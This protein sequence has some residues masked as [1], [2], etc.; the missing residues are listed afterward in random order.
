EEHGDPQRAE[1]I[2]IQCELERRPRYDARWL[3]LH[4]REQSIPWVTRNDWIPKLPSWPGLRW[5]TFTLRRGFAARVRAETI[6]A[7][8]EHAE[9]VFGMAPVEALE[10]DRPDM[11]GLAA[12]PGLSRLR[13]LELKLGYLTCDDLRR[14]I[15][16]PRSAGLTEMCLS[17]GGIARDG[18]EALIQSP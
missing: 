17:S 11:A 13:R 18:V 4:F 16:S 12:I 2:R 10:M 15:D 9:E 1:F 7:F 8:R 5:A 6:A 3:A 14:L